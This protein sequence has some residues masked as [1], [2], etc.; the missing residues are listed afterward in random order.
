MRLGVLQLPSRCGP[1]QRGDVYRWRAQQMLFV[2]SWCR[3]FR[4]QFVSMAVL[5]VRL[6]EQADRSDQVRTHLYD[7]A[8]IQ[9]SSRNLFSRHQK[10][11]RSCFESLGIISTNALSTRRWP[12]IGPTKLLIRGER[13]NFFAWS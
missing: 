1:M 12:G 6:D 13:P 2:A 9:F 10:G 5:L 3:R 4:E 7:A 11:G 8:P